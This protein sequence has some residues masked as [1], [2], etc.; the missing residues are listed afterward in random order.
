MT[1]ALDAY[2]LALLIEVADDVSTGDHT[3]V[4]HFPRPTDRDGAYR[5]LLALRGEAE[6]EAPEPEGCECELDWLCPLH[7]GQAFLPIER[8]NDAWASQDSEPF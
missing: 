8:I 3:L 2:L 5:A 7:Q 4:V 6:D 1:A